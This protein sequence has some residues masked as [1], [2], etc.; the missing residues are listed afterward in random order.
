MA[1][2]SSQR[3]HP[4]FPHGLTFMD[5][6]VTAGLQVLDKHCDEQGNLAATESRRAYEEALAASLKWL[7][8]HPPQNPRS[9][10][11]G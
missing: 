7:A 6:A 5:G 2:S 8:R 11:L 3:V 4:T 9:R 10:K 1:A